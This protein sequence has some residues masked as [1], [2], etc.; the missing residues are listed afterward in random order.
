[1]FLPSFNDVLPLQPINKDYQEYHEN[2]IQEICKS[3]MFPER[4]IPL[5][6]RNTK[7]A[8]YLTYTPTN[9]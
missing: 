5:E 7:I 1:M 8:G 6:V 9:S 2:L 4:R 3:L